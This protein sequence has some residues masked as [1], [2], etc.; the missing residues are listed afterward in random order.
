FVTSTEQTARALRRPLPEKPYRQ[1]RVGTLFHSWVEERS[2]TR[3]TRSSDLFDLS[4]IEQD[5]DEDSGG[6]LVPMAE[7]D[8]RQLAELQKTFERSEWAQ[9]APLHVE[10]EINVVLAGRVVICKLDAVYNRDGRIQIVDWKTGQA[11]RDDEQLQ[12]RQLQLALYRFAYA[13]WSGISP[14]DIDAVF[15]YV[16]DDHVLRPTHINSEEELQELWARVTQPA[17]QPG[18]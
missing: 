11:P 12:E 2:T 6:T 15:Y 9:L 1:T 16:K 10:L 4:A 7:Q 8:R 13:R 3:A 5:S 18:A 17:P 14:D